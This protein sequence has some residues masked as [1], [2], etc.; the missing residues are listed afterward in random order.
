MSRYQDAELVR[1]RAIRNAIS[2]I[3]PE[4][5]FPGQVYEGVWAGFLF[6]QSDYVFSSDFFDV[7]IELLCI[8][9]SKSAALV[10]IEKK[11][12]IDEISGSA[13]FFEKN[14]SPDIYTKK[15]FG[16]SVVDGWIYEFDRYVCATDVGGWAIYCEKSNDI[17]AIALRDSNFTDVYGGALARLSAG[18]IDSLVSGAANLF[19]FNELVVSWRRGLQDNYGARGKW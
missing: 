19:P 7:V 2:S 14:I 5:T 17:A 16:S 11:F 3:D 4:K 13:I 9:N 8:E 18:P 6:F 10:N 12:S 1:N 15:L